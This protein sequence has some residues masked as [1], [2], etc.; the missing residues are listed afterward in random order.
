MRFALVDPPSCFATT[1]WHAVLPAL[2]SKRSAK[3]DAS[4][5]LLTESAGQR[6]GRTWF[7][8]PNPIYGSWLTALGETP[9]AHLRP[10]PRQFCLQAPLPVR[11]LRGPGRREIGHGALAERSIEPM[12]SDPESFPY[13]IRV[14]SDVLQSVDGLHRIENH[15]SHVSS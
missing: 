6:F 2:R 9:A 10:D 3:A 11:F 15:G 8:L 12:I 1:A 7:L 5:F 13:T 4:S 14:V